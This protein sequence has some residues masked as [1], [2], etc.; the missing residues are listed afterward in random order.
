MEPREKLLFPRIYAVC[1]GD[2]KA[3]QELTALLGHIDL[4]Q[5]QNTRYRRGQ[6][7]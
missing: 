7:V 3:L 1:L 6:R 2:P 4:L 5:E